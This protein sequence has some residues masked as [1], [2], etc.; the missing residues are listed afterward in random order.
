MQFMLAAMFIFV[1]V[2]IYFNYKKAQAFSDAQFNVKAGARE[3]T[4]RIQSNFSRSA[5]SVFVFAKVAGEI[6]NENEMVIRQVMAKQLAGLVNPE[7]NIQKAWVYLEP[8]LPGSRALSLQADAGKDTPDE[9][10]PNPSVQKGNSQPVIVF[11]GSNLPGSTGVDWIQIEA[12]VISSGRQA[13][14]V[15]A[16]IDFSAITNDLKAILP[17]PGSVLF[18]RSENG[19]CIYCS[20][21]SYRQIAE[22][23]SMGAADTSALMRDDTNPGEMFLVQKTFDLPY[24]SGTWVL[25]L[26]SP[27]PEIMRKENADFRNILIS[28]VVGM[29]VLGLMVAWIANSLVAPLRAGIDFAKEISEG[30][31]TGKISW[32]RKDESGEL[33]SSL[34]HMA[35][36]LRVTITEIQRVTREIIEASRDLGK[37]SKSLNQAAMN[38]AFITGE[39]ADS[40]KSFAD[41]ISHNTENSRETEKISSEAALAIEAG[42]QSSRHAFETMN[43]VVSRSAVVGEIALQTNILALN[44]AVEAARA[45][46]QGKGFGV[47]AAEVRKLA[48]RSRNAADEINQMSS[49]SLEASTETQKD[50][51]AIVP[52]IARIAG[53]VKAIAEANENQKEELNRVNRS[54]GQLNTLAGKNA[55]TAELLSSRSKELSKLSDDLDGL[56]SGFSV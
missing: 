18:I 2:I 8:G 1:V 36:K 10:E 14:Y 55:D 7:N 25:G 48:E 49:E 19:K 50:M 24:H 44:A 31:L 22:N 47:V 46:E 17:Y 41:A 56:I 20:D 12:P 27:K 28:G 6:A 21:S 34:T 53:L 30:N 35:D 33:V 9:V 5:G 38:Q 32:H 40:M 29:L 39:V 3:G 15:A 42:E 54:I 51:E 16:Q 26:L 52:E 4:I 23:V 11:S 45:G 13:G 43:A 37:S